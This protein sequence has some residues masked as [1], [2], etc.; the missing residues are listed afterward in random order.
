MVNFADRLLQKIDETGNPT[1][2]GL[3]PMLDY[4]P[5]SIL[6][7]A[8]AAAADPADAAG[9]AIL[10]FNCR[11]IDAVVDLIPAVK[12]Q[13]AYYEQYGA[14][15]YLALQQT[16]A[17]AKA[18][19]MI[20]IADAKRNDIGST[21]EAYARAI[22]GQ[23]SLGRDESGQTIA[24]SFLGADAVT[25]NGYLGSDGIQ[26]FLKQLQPDGQGVFVLVRT[27]NP[28]AGDLQD[29]LLTDGRTVYEAMAGLVAEWG[30]PYGVNLAIRRSEPS[31]R[32]RGHA[33]LSS[34]ALSCRTV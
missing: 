25:L 24:R 8:R 10:T 2:M 14:A 17:Y 31:S 16:I 3:D 21:A 4:I 5:E 23:T 13:F 33:R 29:Q 32:P 28:S 26:P 34:C 9:Q 1:V 30:E 18:R 12:P 20:V 6:K 11:L 22:L 15:G 7:E 19:G 27:S